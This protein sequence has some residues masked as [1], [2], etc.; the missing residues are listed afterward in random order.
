MHGYTATPAHYEQTN[1]QV[2][3]AKG[4]GGQAKEEDAASACGHSGAL[5]ASSAGRSGPQGP[6]V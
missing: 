5:R 1:S 2:I 3:A 4:A 6:R